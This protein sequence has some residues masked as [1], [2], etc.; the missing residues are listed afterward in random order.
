MLSFA[1]VPTDP[2]RTSSPRSKVAVAKYGKN[3]PWVSAI[4][5]QSKEYVTKAHEFLS[6][7]TELQF[8]ES[9]ETNL[10]EEL[11]GYNII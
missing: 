7:L 5:Q 2:N 3:T 4:F 11:N 10:I 9:R 6:I 8:F 1:A